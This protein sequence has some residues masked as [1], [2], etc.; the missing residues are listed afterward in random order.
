MRRHISNDRAPL[1]V[2]V[3]LCKVKFSQ[4]LSLNLLLFASP[5][6]KGSANILLLPKFSPTFSHVFYTD[7]FRNESGFLFCLFVLL[8]T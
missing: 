5:S 1:G 7:L 4:V 6:S 3:Y 2:E 8:M